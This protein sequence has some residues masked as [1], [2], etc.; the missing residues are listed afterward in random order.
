MDMRTKLGYE[1]YVES[2]G[3]E[4]LGVVHGRWWGE[5][6]LTG[7]GLNLKKDQKV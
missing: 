7:V 3:N 2:C 4:M 6:V 5:E 1:M